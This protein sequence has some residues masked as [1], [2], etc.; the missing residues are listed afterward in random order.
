[1]V[2]QYEQFE[3]FMKNPKSK[4][5]KSEKRLKIQK[6]IDIWGFPIVQKIIPN[7]VSVIT[8]GA[9][10]KRKFFFAARSSGESP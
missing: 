10:K 2:D 9:T 7:N 5:R 3:A 4:V 8:D 1:L 6:A